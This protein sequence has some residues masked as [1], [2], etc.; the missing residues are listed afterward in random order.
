VKPGDEVIVP[1]LTW[2]SSAN[3]IIYAGAVPVFCDIEPDSLSVSSRTILAA[4]T[5]K[6]KAVIVVHF[7]GLAVDVQ[8]VREALPKSVS[9]IEDAAHALGATYPEGG[10]VGSSGNPVCFSFYANKNLSTGEGGAVA[11]GDQEGA[12]LIRSLRQHGLPTDAWKRFTHPKAIGSGEIHRLGFKANYTDLQAAIGRVQ[13]RRQPEFAAI[14]IGIARRYESRLSLVAPGFSSQ[15]RLGDGGHSR[16]LFVAKLPAA[17]GR[18]RRDA[19]LISLRARN[20]GASVHYLP[21]HQMPYYSG[22]A[23][24]PL[25]VTDEI[26]PRLIT[27]PISASMTEADAEDVLCALESA[28]AEVVATIPPSI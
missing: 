25:G 6:T 21:L 22:F 7:G 14:R 12:E 16:H 18:P 10:L 27:L 2:C 1:S 3:A 17:A 20:I 9:I 5:P 26:A 4:V 24:S 28:W 23:H 11:L 15:L 19:L 13:L 8:S